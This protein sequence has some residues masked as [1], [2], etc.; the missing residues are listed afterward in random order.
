MEIAKL[1][2]KGQIT[3]PKA[4]RE[5]LGVVT[6]DKLIFIKC[7]SGYLVCNGDNFNATVDETTAEVSI[8]A[9]V[10]ETH[11]APSPAPRA[12]KRTPDYYYDE[13]DEWDEKPKKDKDKGKDKDKDK[14]KKKKKKKKK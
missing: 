1:T 6:G 2:S 3:I 9:F 7:D 11:P 13:E 8:P 10:R 5:N 12:E 4:V 14:D